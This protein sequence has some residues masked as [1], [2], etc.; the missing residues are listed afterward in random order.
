MVLKLDGNSAIGAHEQS[1]FYLILRSATYNYIMV[2]VWKLL[3]VFNL[4]KAF[5]RS[6]AKFGILSPKRPNFLHA[7]ATYFELP[8]N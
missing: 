6:R 2:S 8:P 7:C 1:L 3:Y 4:F 5:D